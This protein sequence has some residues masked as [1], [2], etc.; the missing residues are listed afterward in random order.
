MNF[1]QRGCGK[2]TPTA[3]LEANTTWDLVADIEKVR[4]TSAS[5]A[6]R[7]SADRGARP[8]RSP[9]R[10]L[11]RSAPRNWS[12]ASSSSA[13]AG[14]RRWFYHV[15]RL[16]SPPTRGSRTR[17][18]SRGRARRPAL[19]HYRRMTSDDPAGDSRPRKIGADGRGPLPSSCP[20]STPPAITRRMSRPRL[21][22]HRGPL[23]H[24][25]GFL[26]DRR[27][28]GRQRFARIRLIPGESWRPLRR[29]L[30]DGKRWALHRAWPEPTHPPPPQRPRA[31]STPRTSRPGRGTDKFAGRAP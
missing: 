8:W 2:S 19:R 25:Q 27:P 28:V 11:I 26:R 15:A 30:S 12:A 5:S 4:E 20:T 1:D 23:L 21:R 29:R 14:D 18:H 22:A 24:Q 3:S 16:S 13:R 31:F 7:C 9:M 17:P 6:G 10:K